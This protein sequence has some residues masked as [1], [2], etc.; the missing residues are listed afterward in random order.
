MFLEA[1]PLFAD[2]SELRA[3]EAAFYAGPAYASLWAAWA[4]VMHS[5]A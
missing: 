2:G 5:G 3:I 4:Q 1:G